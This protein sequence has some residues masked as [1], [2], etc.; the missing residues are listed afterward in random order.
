[1]TATRPAGENPTPGIPSNNH[2]TRGIEHRH[3][4]TRMKCHRLFSPDNHMLKTLA[5]SI[6]SVG[7]GERQQQPNM[8]I[9]VVGVRVRFKHVG[10]IT[11]FS[12]PIAV[13]FWSFALQCS[14][15]DLSGVHGDVF[16]T[17]GV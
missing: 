14:D 6:I 7:G 4:T 9:T 15:R 5:D 3:I 13:T 11:F 16:N 10:N 8:K 1:M 2:P 17:P 12:V